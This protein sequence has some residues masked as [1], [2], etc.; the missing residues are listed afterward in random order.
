[1]HHFHWIM[2]GPFI[3][4]VLLIGNPW[5][6]DSSIQLMQPMTKQ[7]QPYQHYSLIVI[8]PLVQTATKYRSAS[9]QQSNLSGLPRSTICGSIGART[10]NL[11][12]C[13]TS[14]AFFH[15]TTCVLALPGGPLCLHFNHVYGDSVPL[16]CTCPQMTIIVNNVTW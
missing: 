13:I 2:R 6:H 15:Y 1:M 12:L 10:H 5:N 9:G 14:P 11:K 16:F 8:V 7:A 3:I 4:I